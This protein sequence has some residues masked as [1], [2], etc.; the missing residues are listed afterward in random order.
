MTKRDVLFF[1]LILVGVIF[2]TAGIFNDFSLDEIWSYDM[3]TASASAWGALITTVENHPL[4]NL[5]IYLMGEQRFWWIYRIPSLIASLAALGVI[6]TAARN[7]RRMEGTALLLFFSLSYL[8]VLYGSEARGY[9]AMILFSLLAWCF[10]ERYLAGGPAR[11]AFGYSACV[12]LSFLAHFGAVQF[13]MAA[14][15]WSSLLILERNGMKKGFVRAFS[16]NAGPALFIASAWILHLRYLEK[17]SGNVF[18]PLDLIVNTVCLGFGAPP[19]SSSSPEMTLALV[20]TAAVI[21]AF[22]LREIIELRREHEPRWSYY[23]LAIFIVPI[24]TVVSL[25]R[26]SVEPRYFLISVVFAWFVIA[27]ALE[28]WAR[29]DLFGRTLALGFLAAFTVGNLLYLRTFMEHGRGHYLAALEYIAQNRQQGASA[30]VVSGDFDFRNR[31]IIDFYRKYLPDIELRYAGKDSPDRADAMW[32]F[33]HSQD[34]EYRAA[35]EVSESGRRFR[36][37]KVFPYTYGSGW[38]WYLYRAE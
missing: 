7:M 26:E 6:A 34:P 5:F 4:N 12:I 13:F 36:L 24:L 37:M 19:L 20:P 18:H 9:S 28:R 33:A 27:G 8:M 35:P 14:A 3:A 16:L 1:I 31:M 21:V 38:T 32:Y 10:L 29:R 30:T 17:A 25:N 15:A 2:R 11:D 23:L 22:V